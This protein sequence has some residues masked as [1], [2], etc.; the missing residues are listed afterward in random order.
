MPIFHT[1]RIRV[2]LAASTLAFSAAA[3][4]NLI[5]NG[6][7]ETGTFLP[8]SNQTMTLAPG[9]TSLTGWTV[10]DDSIAWIGVG[11]PW[12]LD[13]LS[14]DRFL[15]LS[16]YSAG[17]PFGGVSQSIATVA[18][19]EYTVTFA[20]GSSNRWGRP[21]ALKVTAGGTSATFTSATTG[22]N[23][24]WDIHSMTFIATGATTNITFTGVS[25]A[26]YIG[27]D[28]VVVTGVP[29]PESA[30]LVLAGAGVLVVRSRR[31][32]RSTWS[33]TLFT[34]LRQKQ[35]AQVHLTRPRH[36]FK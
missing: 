14:G 8:P 33:A 27:L 35:L 18:G 28:D 34:H 26:N 29:E 16:D 6:S 1:P 19:G 4:A 10:V 7:F 3:Q 30:L 17:A 5:T 21:S 24:D 12:S 36:H 23:N 2:L 20:L 32:R 15:D 13:A 25:G 9:S 31:Q 22:T 11:D